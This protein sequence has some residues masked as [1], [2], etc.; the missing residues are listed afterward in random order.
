MKMKI[1]ETPKPE[2]TEEDTPT[3]AKDKIENQLNQFLKAFR[4]STEL[5]LEHDRSV[6]W[7]IWSQ[8]I[9]DFY[10]DLDVVLS[11]DILDKCA[12]CGE[13]DVASEFEEKGFCLKC[14]EK[15]DDEGDEWA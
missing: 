8:M 6:N 4:E 9:T 14:K 1:L 3:I 12:E 7:F 15:E 2:A 13:V 11:E 10:F 5:I